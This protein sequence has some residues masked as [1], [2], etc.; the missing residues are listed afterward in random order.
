MNQNNT[1]PLY[2]V[3]AFPPFSRAAIQEAQA[4]VQAPIALVGGV[5]LSAMSLATQDL[6]NVR[7]MNGLVSACSL[8]TL[9]ISDS[10]D[11]KTAV[12]K[13]FVAPFI[14]YQEK[15]DLEYQ[16]ALEHYNASRK[17]WKI[18]QK[19][20]T[21]QFDKALSEGE[22]A[23]DIKLALIEHAR[24]E[25]I[26]PRGTKL[27]YNDATPAAFLH[28]LH[29]NSRSAGLIDDEAGRIFSSNLVNDLGMLNKAWDGSD[30]HVDRRTSESFVVKAPRVSISW[31]LQE[32]VFNKYLERKGDQAR[33]IGFLARGLIARPTSIQGTRFIQGEAIEPEALPKYHDRVTQLLQLR[34][35]MGNPD[36]EFNRAELHF[37]PEAQAEWVA[38][39][40]QIEQHINPGGVFCEHRDY[41]SKVAENIARVAAVFHCFEGYEG[42]SIS[43]QTLR[44][45][46]TV[47]L[48]YAQEFVRLF[49]PPDP[50]YETIKDAYLLQDWLLKIFRSRSW[51]VIP[52]N[53]ILQR[54]PN[55]LRSKD[56]LDWALNC[57]CAGA[58]ISG[59]TQGRKEFVHL[60]LAFFGPAA[61][62]QEMFGFLPLG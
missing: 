57:L 37:S 39:Y 2:P 43:L 22:F 9:E 28:G 51:Q 35:T 61:Q 20:L 1:L 38:V 25:P 5:A 54:G 34:A 6:V 26:A 27:I 12:E 52:K 56:R 49:S 47:V 7:R 50:L 58:R 29:A 24:N 53:F 16:E 33:G 55:P 42:V 21:R 40:N 3:W 18:E 48:W 45:A 36:G 19:V 23:E 41:A 17:V 60:N 59:S 8:F 11:R 44:S 4:M 14:A 15:Q 62:G 30:I 10:G 46:V 32:L 13:P 31:M